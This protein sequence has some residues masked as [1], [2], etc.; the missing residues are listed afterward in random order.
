MTAPFLRVA[1]LVAALCALVGVVLQGDVGLG[2]DAVALVIVV[3]IPL[4][5]VVHLALRWT[6]ERD[7]VF[8]LAAWG[9]V[10]LA[11]TGAGMLALWR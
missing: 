8:A 7:T 11:I 2:L 4:L 6:R 10:T 1:V 3:A 9:L 5:R